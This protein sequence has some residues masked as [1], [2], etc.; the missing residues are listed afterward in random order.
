MST[1]TQIQTFTANSENEMASIFAG[2]RIKMLCDLKKQ[3]RIGLSQSTIRE[4]VFKE[5]FLP[6]Y[7]RVENEALPWQMVVDL[8]VNSLTERIVIQ[9]VC[10][11]R[12][13]NFEEADYIKNR[14]FSVLVETMTGSIKEIVGNL[15]VVNETE[16][17]KDD[18][19]KVAVSAF[20]HLLCEFNPAKRYGKHLVEKFVNYIYQLLKFRTIDLLGIKNKDYTKVVAYCNHYESEEEMEK[21]TLGLAV[22][23]NISQLSEIVKNFSNL[24]AVVFN[25]YV[26]LSLTVHFQPSI[27]ELSIEIGLSPYELRKS[28]KNIYEAIGSYFLDKKQTSMTDVSKSIAD[29]IIYFIKNTLL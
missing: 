20:F 18:I 21:D 24:D 16:E 23:N 1:L 29:E 4:I 13:L 10:L 12:F 11:H 27:E 3:D 5:L 19:E 25:R 22:Q 17:E 7:T 8:F 28:V 9:T 6:F 15:F 2:S 14:V 26:S